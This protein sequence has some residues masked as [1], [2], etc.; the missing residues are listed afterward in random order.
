MAELWSILTVVGATIIGAYGSLLFK[1]G[2]DSLSLEIK[3][4]V[5]NYTIMTGFLLYGVSALIFMVALRGGE[6]SVLYPFVAT[7]Y[8]WVCL[9]SGKYLNERMNKFKWVGVF[10]IIVGVSLIGMGS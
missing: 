1:K 4:L 6:L 9:L 8:I 10:L 7:S 5:T 2:S 3:K